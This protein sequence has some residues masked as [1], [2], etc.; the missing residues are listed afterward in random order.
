MKG[1]KCQRCIPIKPRGV[2]IG[3]NLFVTMDDLWL[4]NRW[5]GFINPLTSH[6]TVMGQKVAKRAKAT[7][8]QEQ[9]TASQKKDVGREDTVRSR[10]PTPDPPTDAIDKIILLLYHTNRGIARLPDSPS[11]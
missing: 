10:E 9:G 4:L 5:K 8:E 2:C 6:M 3:E 11:N 7:Q 1:G